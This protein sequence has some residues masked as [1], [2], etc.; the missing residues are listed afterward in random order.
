M[1][2]AGVMGYEPRNSSL[3]LSLAAAMQ[4]Q[5]SAVL[6]MTFWYLPGGSLAGST[7]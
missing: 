5:A 3:P 1:S 7:L 4:P 6:P 2:L